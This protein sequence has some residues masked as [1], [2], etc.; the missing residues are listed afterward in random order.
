[1]LEESRAKMTSV[2]RECFFSLDCFDFFLVCLILV[3]KKHSERGCFY[4]EF[5][6]HNT[7]IMVLKLH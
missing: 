1:M 6:I 4:L 7:Y 5:N 3:T 2:R